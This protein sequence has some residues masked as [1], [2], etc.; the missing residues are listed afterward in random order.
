M[1]FAIRFLTE[2]RYDVAGDRQPQRAA[3]APGDDLH[4]ALRRV[5]HAHRA[6]GAR[7]PP[8]RLLRHRGARVRHP[9]RPRA[10]DDRRARARGHLRAARAARRLVGEPAAAPPTSTRRASSRCPGRTSRRSRASR[11]ATTALDADSSAGDP[12]AALRAGPRP[13]RI[14]PRRRPTSARA[15]A[16]CSRRARACA[17]TSC[18]S[19]WCCCAAAASPRA[20]SRAICGRRPRTAARTRWRSTRTRGWRR[21][22]PAPTDTASR[23]GSGADPT[24]RRL[25]GETHVKIGHGRFYADVPPVKGLYLGGAH[26]ELTAAVTMSRLDPQASARA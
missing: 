24:N 26:S 22:C 11:A 20:T 12:G 6:R 18:T 2:Y 17:R 3:R 7:Q 21:C 19:R 1:H 8:P 25:A 16:T 5:P 23:C 13:L 15:S 14:P 9:H 10:A 4:A